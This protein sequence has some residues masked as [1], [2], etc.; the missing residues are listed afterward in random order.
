MKKNSNSF[1][2]AAEAIIYPLLLL[3]VM[4]VVFWAERVSGLNLVQYGIQPKQWESWKGVLFMPLLHSPNDWAHIVNNSIPTF[5]LLSALVYYYRAV[6]LRVVAISWL[7]T[8]LGIWTLAEDNGSFHIGMSGVVYALFGFLFFSGFFRNY[9]PLQGVTL[10]IGFLYGSMFWGIFP[11]QTNVSWEGHLMGLGIGIILAIIYR[12]EGPK[13]PKYQYEIEQEM[14]IEPPDLEGMWL[15]RLAQ[16]EEH[17]Q[18]LERQR[19]LEQIR[20]NMEQQQR[21]SL[22]IVYTYKPKDDTTN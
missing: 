19:A 16:Q 3:L 10:F 8:G 17:A 22:H 21:Q 4:W 15:Q 11:Q 7:V 13:A 1:G 14:G 5:M 18:E 12:S 9:R 6:A 20:L 2:S